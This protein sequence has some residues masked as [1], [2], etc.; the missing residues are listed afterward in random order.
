MALQTRGSEDDDTSSKDTH[1]KGLVRSSS[2]D[3]SDY[4]SLCKYY[5]FP[6]AESD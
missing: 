3:V 1:V 4:A 2:D 6:L 5:V